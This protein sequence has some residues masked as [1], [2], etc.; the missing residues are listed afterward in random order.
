MQTRRTFLASLAAAPLA[1]ADAGHGPM[2]WDYVPD[3]IGMFTTDDRHSLNQETRE[4]SGRAGCYRDPEAVSREPGGR[5]APAGR[6]QANR[7][8]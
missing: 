3:K 4:A 7:T 2:T 1:R 5:A 6:R 8:G